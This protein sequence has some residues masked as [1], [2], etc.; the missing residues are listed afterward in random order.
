VNLLHAGS[1]ATVLGHNTVAAST[2]GT[3]LRS[4]TFGHIR[5]LDAVITATIDSIGENDWVD[6]AYNDDGT[7]QVAEPAGTAGG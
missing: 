4:L 7:A 6:I 5:Q 3:W 2:V 1:T